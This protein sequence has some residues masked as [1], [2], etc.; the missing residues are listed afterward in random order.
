MLGECPIRCTQVAL[1]TLL[2]GFPGLRLAGREEDIV[3][4]A[5]SATRAPERM[6][7]TWDAPGTPGRR[8]A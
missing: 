6:P 1:R 2:D 3:W 4:K 8:T 5:G 7:V